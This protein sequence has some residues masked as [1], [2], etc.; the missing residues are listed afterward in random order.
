MVRPFR[1]A[2]AEARR[3]G[4]LYFAALLPEDRILK[5]FG[6]A[7]ANWRGWVY[8]PANTVWVFLSQCLSADHSCRDAVARL[9]AWLVAQGRR[10]CSAD[11]GGYCTA[12]G[13]RREQPLSHASRCP[14]RRRRGTCRPL[15]QRLV[16]H[17]P[18][19]R[20]RHR[21]R[22][23]Q[24]SSPPYGL[25]QGR[26]VGRRRPLGFLEQ[27]SAAEVD[28]GGAIRRIARRVDVARGSHSRRSER[29]SHAV[30]GGRNDARRC[31]ALSARSD[32]SALPAA[33]A[34]GIASAKLEDCFTDGPS[35]VQNSRAGSQRVLYPSS[36][37]QS[38]SRRDGKGGI[39]S[40]PIARGNQLQGN[41]AN[42]PAVPADPSDE[43]FQRKVVRGVVDGR[44]HTRGG[45]SA[46][47][48][49]APPCQTP[50]QTLQTP[51][52]TSTQL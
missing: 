25:S 45:Q 44:G 29:L 18:A 49:R 24:A 15:F 35:A 14:E 39:R 19:A 11:T 36:R 8:T 12:R 43:R 6:A 41:A 48:F 23:P 22:G 17:R 50:P 10:P 52:R 46:R 28:V 9:I 20:P 13:D 3:Q 30:A 40:G 1:A 47:P 27:T 5:A 38:P 4:Q 32:C 37:L 16:R 31:G 2:V 26:A 42:A 21:R 51:P 7:R 34:G 33:M